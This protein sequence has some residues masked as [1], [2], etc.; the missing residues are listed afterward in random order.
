MK[1]NHLKSK[2]VS[3]TLYCPRNKHTGEYVT[4]RYE[5]TDDIF[6]AIGWGSIKQCEEDITHFDE[7]EDWEVA[8]KIVTMTMLDVADGGD[9]DED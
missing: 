9:V 6:E 3:H 4:E 2:S 1:V 5:S 8:I 7:P